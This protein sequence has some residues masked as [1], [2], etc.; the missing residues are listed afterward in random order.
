MANLSVRDCLVAALEDL[1]NDE[2]KRFKAKLSELPVREGYD[3]LPRGRLQKADDLDLSDL[4]V[5]HY[6]EGYAVEVAAAALG[7]INCQPQAERLRRVI[8]RDA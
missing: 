7:A 1:A 5:S 8:R 6:T 2:L 4:L 3:N